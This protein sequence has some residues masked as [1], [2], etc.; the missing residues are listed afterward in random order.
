MQF[1][2]RSVLSQAFG[3]LALPAIF[4]VAPLPGPET[5]HEESREIERKDVSVVGWIMSPQKPYVRV[6]TP[7]T[8][9][10][11]LAQRQA[12]CRGDEVK[13]RLVGRERSHS[14]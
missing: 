10:C 2:Q 1:P 12:L 7:S 14:T 4:S 11:G 13:M 8:L 6:P 5:P 9:Q 3:S